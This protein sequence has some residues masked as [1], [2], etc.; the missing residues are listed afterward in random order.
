MNPIHEIIAD[1]R[2]HFAFCQEVFAIIE[3]EN[4][5]L[6]NPDKTP[7]AELHK[8]KRDLLPRLNDLLSKLR[9]HRNTWRKLTPADRAGYPEVATL[10][11]QNQDLIMKVIVLDRE[12]EQAL[13][14]RGLVP[15][16]SLPSAHRQKPHYVA[17][18]YRRQG[19]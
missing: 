4:Y 6:R 15:V 5:A 9:Q 11:Q 16:R 14:R 3:R 12:K 8:A 2:R 7:G 1:L 17:E 13:L 18:L 10:L 19:T